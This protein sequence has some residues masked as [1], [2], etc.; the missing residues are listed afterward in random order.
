MTEGSG[1]TKGYDARWMSSGEGPKTYSDD[2]FTDMIYKA[3]ELEGKSNMR[4]LDWMSG[5]GKVGMAMREISGNND[6]FFLDRSEAATKKLGVTGEKAVR[7]EAVAMPF[8]NASMDVVVARYAVKDLPADQQPA[9]FREAF[10]VLKPDG[11][12]V[13]A[14][15]ITA[16]EDKKRWINQQHLKKQIMSGRNTKTEGE[17]NLPTEKEWTE[18][19]KNA[20]FSVD[21]EVQQYVSEVNTNDWIPSQITPEQREEMDTFILGADDGLKKLYNIRSE[22]DGVQINFPVR[23]FSAAK[24]Q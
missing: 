20:G 10:R 15:M 14:D 16:E 12:L 17:C 6:V 3:T 13:I 7:A 11:R 9:A 4:I 18:L 23:I 2:S 8:P 21:P 19:M 1:L 24:K 22:Q 5:P